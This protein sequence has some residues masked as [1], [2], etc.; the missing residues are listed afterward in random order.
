MESNS[1]QPIMDQTSLFSHTSTTSSPNY[2]PSNQNC[3][4]MPDSPPPAYEVMYPPVKMV[5]RQ[6]TK[7]SLLSPIPIIGSMS[8]QSLSSGLQIETTSIKINNTNNNNN[9]QFQQ[10]PTT[11]KL[12]KLNN[13][14]IISSID[15]VVAQNN[16]DVHDA[17]KIE[18]YDQQ[19]NNQ[20]QQQLGG[21]NKNVN[22]KRGP[23]KSKKVEGG[24]LL[25]TKQPQSR[26]LISS[27]NQSYPTT[28]KNIYKNKSAKCCCG[29][30]IAICTEFTLEVCCRMF[31]V[32]S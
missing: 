18:Q 28:D 32:N 2:H 27:K 10:Q 16:D 31:F 29:F 3:Y 23:K 19:T 7:T 17:T 1:Q 21:K 11:S 12:Q 20:E 4:E 24:Y 22:W 9:N 8:E 15:E 13:E 25:T 30:F 26:K 14:S 5:N 6:Q